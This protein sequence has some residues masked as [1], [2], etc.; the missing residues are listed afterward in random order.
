MKTNRGKLHLPQATARAPTSMVMVLSP[1][2]PGA[3]EFLQCTM[4][5]IEIMWRRDQLNYEQYNAALRLGRAQETVNG[6]GLGGVMDFD[7]PRGGGGHSTTPPPAT[8]QA[9]AYLRQAKH[10]LYS[11]DHQVVRL[12]VFEGRTIEQAAVEIHGAEPS[13][14]QK[15]DTGHKLRAALDHLAETWWGKAEGTGSKVRAFRDFAAGKQVGEAGVITPGK[16]AHAVAGKVS[17]S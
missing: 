16:V 9:A 13:H 3:T 17:H 14:S 4:S 7:R 8:L 11:R 15:R 10:T 2:V 6:A 1:T 5:T 12:V